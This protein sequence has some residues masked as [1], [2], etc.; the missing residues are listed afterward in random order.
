M[1]PADQQQGPL[2]AERLRQLV[3]SG[4]FLRQRVKLTVAGV[5]IGLALAFV[6]RIFDH[7]SDSPPTSFLLTGMA[8]GMIALGISLSV[9]VEVRRRRKSILAG[10]G[11]SDETVPLPISGSF[12]GVATRPPEIVGTSEGCGFRQ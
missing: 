3:I 6:S 9:E 10:V 4:L 2:S 12:C 8:G 5:G 1:L 11:Q 7:L